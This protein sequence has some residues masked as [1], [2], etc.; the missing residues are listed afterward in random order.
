MTQPAIVAQDLT[1]SYGKLMALDGI[2]FEVNEGEVLGFLGPNGAGKT[3]AVRILT[4][5]L[6]PQRG[7]AFVLGKDMRT[8]AKQ[9]QQ[10]LGVSFEN[11]NLYE[12]MSA[13]ENLHLF[14]R[15]FGLRQFDALELLEKVGLKGREKERVANYSKGMKQRV[16][17]GCAIIHQPQVLFL[18]EP[19]E[20]LDVQ[21]RRMIAGCSRKP[22]PPC[23]RTR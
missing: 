21:S 5:Q 10:Y 22:R 6:Q 18:D 19:T 17:I 23:A 12:D 8:H 2:S 16:S 14:A 20:G 4:G 1:Y 3:T 13:V 9:V 15:L 11:A 7:S